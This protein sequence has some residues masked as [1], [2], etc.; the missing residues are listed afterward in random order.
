MESSGHIS[1]FGLYGQVL[2]CLNRQ[3]AD[4]ADSGPPKPIEMNHRTF[5]VIDNDRNLPTVEGRRIK[6][7]ALFNFADGSGRFFS[8]F[9]PF[10]VSSYDTVV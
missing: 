7:F 9:P 4:A 8:S 2:H 1:V 10:H 5:G 3:R 6:S